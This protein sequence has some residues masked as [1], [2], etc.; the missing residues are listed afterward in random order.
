MFADDYHKKGTFASYTFSTVVHV[1][2]LILILMWQQHKR[3]ALADYTLT[4]ITMIQEIPDV[5]RPVALEKP[6]KMFD[7][8]KQIIPIKQKVQLAV[9]KPQDIKLDKPKL[10]MSKPQA[11][12]MDKQKLDMK[13][14]MKAI[15]LENEIG[16]KAISP[17]MVK[18]QVALQKQQQLAQAPA[19]KLD[20]SNK[21]PKSSFLPMAGK[22]SI[23]TD[24]RAP[25]GLKQSA[26]K[27]GQP[28]PEPKVKS[29][30]DESIN[31]PKKQALLI[32]GDVAGRGILVAKKPSYPRWLQNQGVEAAVTLAFTVMQDGTVKDT[33][34][35]ERTSGYTELDDLAKEALLQFKF[36]PIDTAGDQSGYATFRYIL[37]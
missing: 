7:F 17:A 13:P 3:K 25:S 16:K 8:L 30:A 21:A 9:S 31:I 32:Q 2:I 6:K 27:L 37:E 11:L 29:M 4:E 10:E 23:S 5:Q 15:D 14:A 26:F 18:A 1:L 19:N 33:V 35:V 22:P 24:A 20:L 34:M 28:T 36:V 12:S